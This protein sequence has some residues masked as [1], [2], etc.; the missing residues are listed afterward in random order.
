VV[1]ERR[2]RTNENARAA[3]IAF[4]FASPP[5]AN[6]N[7]YSLRK[8]SVSRPSRTRALGSSVRRARLGREKKTTRL[9]P[10]CFDRETGV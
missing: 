5:F 8:A 6:F 3:A 9:E 4:A 7:F 10:N 1:R 2:T